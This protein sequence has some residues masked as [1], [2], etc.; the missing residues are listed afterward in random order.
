MPVILIAEDE[1]DI[2][3]LLAMH[4]RQE[5]HSI[6]EAADGQEAL[7]LFARSPVDLILLDVM[8]PRLNGFQ[9]LTRVRESS[10]IPV[11][12]LTAQLE[13]EDKILGLGLGA[14]DYV[15]KPFSLLEIASRVNAQLRR[16]L[17]YSGGSRRVI[18]RNGPLEMDCDNYTAS[19][20]GQPLELNPKE[21]KI[22]S[23]LMENPGKVFTKKQLYESIWEEVYYGDSNTIMV[24]IS[25]LREKIEDNPKDPRYLKTIRGIGYRMEKI[26]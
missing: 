9:V 2:R 22:L 3:H 7:E 12:F 6:L 1:E 18:L 5:G 23:L 15:V 10:D 19:K 26:T 11:M 17:T 21:F 8:M 20:N 4:L 25:H 24:H 14:D 13:E 16:F